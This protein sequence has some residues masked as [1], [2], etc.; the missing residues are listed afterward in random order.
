V[1]LPGAR[2][3]RYGHSCIATRATRQHQAGVE[4]RH[5]PTILGWDI[6]DGAVDPGGSDD[7]G[8]QVDL[9]LGHGAGSSQ[10]PAV[11]RASKPSDLA[12]PEGVKG[13]SDLAESQPTHI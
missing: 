13:Q 6:L 10:G 2:Q 8:A 12:E 11:P 5:D 9:E 7:L 3:Q 1:C 4:Y